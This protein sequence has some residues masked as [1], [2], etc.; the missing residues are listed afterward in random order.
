MARVGIANF[1]PSDTAT[2]VRRDMLW[3]E[4]CSRGYWPHKY[5]A[6]GDGGRA[7][8]NAYK[9]PLIDCGLLKH[10]RYYTPRSSRSSA[11]SRTL[12]HED[13]LGV[14]DSTTSRKALAAER[15]PHGTFYDDYVKTVCH[16]YKGAAGKAKQIYGGKSMTNYHRSLTNE[17]TM[18]K[19]ASEPTVIVHCCRSYH[20]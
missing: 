13:W 5:H 11:R 16:M 15:L 20:R 19:V 17:D 9:F 12:S 3:R 2:P 10:D 14:R 1:W 4:T 6:L 18:R 7:I 8:E